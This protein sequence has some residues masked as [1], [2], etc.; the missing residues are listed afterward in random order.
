VRKEFGWTDKTGSESCNEPSGSEG[1][2]QKDGPDRS[3]VSPVAL[4]YSQ[5]QGPV[6]ILPHGSAGVKGNSSCPPQSGSR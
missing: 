2:K 5:D 3:S 1:K 4:V 6:C